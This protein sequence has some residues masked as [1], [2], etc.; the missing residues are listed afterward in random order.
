MDAAWDSIETGRKSGSELV[1]GIDK[2]VVRRKGRCFYMIYR[3]RLGLL[4]RITRIYGYGPWYTPWK[5]SIYIYCSWL[6]QTGLELHQKIKGVYPM[7]RM[8][9]SPIDFKF[10]FILLDKL[11]SYCIFRPACTGYGYGGSSFHPIQHTLWL[12]KLEGEDRCRQVSHTL[13]GSK[14]ADEE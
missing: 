8:P 12:P 9:S 2:T 1:K 10:D 3:S 4:G 7:M 11:R 6:L 13:I 14:I 5:Y